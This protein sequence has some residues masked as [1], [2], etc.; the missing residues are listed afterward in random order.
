MRKEGE[1]S[2]Q[3][4]RGQNLIS[5]DFGFTLTGGEDEGRQWGTALYVADSETK[6]VLR[7]PVVEAR[8]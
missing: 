5:F 7:I 6:A 3:K 1:R 4:D 2:D 8:N